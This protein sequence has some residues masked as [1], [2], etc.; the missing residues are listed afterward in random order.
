MVKE[1]EVQPMNPPKF[2]MI[3]DMAMLT[4]L[5]EASVLYNLKRRYSHW[6][7]YVSRGCPGDRD[8]HPL[9]WG[10]EGVPGTPRP[11]STPFPLTDLLRALLRHH[12]PLQVAA[13]L[14][15]ARGGGL[16]GQAAL[17][18]APAHLLHRRQRLQ[19]HA[20]Q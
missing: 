8:G 10:G 14:H 16:Q 7:I 4:H 1:D 6:M 2:D 5:N 13:R 11:S 17:R 9:G 3:E 19:R 12:Q 18:G 20:A 15:R